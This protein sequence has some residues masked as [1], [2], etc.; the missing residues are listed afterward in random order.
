MIKIK[1]S[2]V[3]IIAI[4]V[5]ITAC[6]G[7]VGIAHCNKYKITFELND[8]LADG[9]GKKAKVILLG[10][11]SNASGCSL[12]EYLEKNV[13]PEKF[14]EYQSGYNNVYIN[15]LSGSNT[16]KAFVKCATL[17]GELAGGFGPELG[18]AEK[19]NEMY[20]NELF[21]IIKC[22]WGGTNLYE[23]WLSPSSS[24]KT[25]KLYK[26]F[27]AFVSQSLEYLQSKNYDIEVEGMCWMQGESD[28]LDRETAIEYESNLSNFINDIRDKFKGY[29]SSNGIAFIDAKIAASFFWTHYELVNQ[30]K[31]N[32]ENLSPL[33][34]LIDTISEGL[35]VTE[36]PQPTPDIAHY[37]SLSEIKLGNLF[38]EKISLY[39]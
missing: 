20:P 36:E 5:A 24:G 4:I 17:Q 22:A 9:N 27:I 6:V 1:R 33:N 34:V 30:S 31:A 25:G 28:S 13:S 35:T 39:F 23:E 7:I 2:I 14:A 38:A 26:Q 10:G 12:V 18:L 15:Y 32:V 8:T 21:F 19:L 11:Q 29:S 3:I 16:S 37:D